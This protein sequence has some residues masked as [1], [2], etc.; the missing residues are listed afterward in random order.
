M[1]APAGA[2]LRAAYGRLSLSARLDF[3]LRKTQASGQDD[4]GFGFSNCVVTV[5]HD[6]DNGNDVFQQSS[7]KTAFL[8]SSSP[9]RSFDQ[10]RQRFL[11]IPVEHRRVWLR[12]ERVLETRKPL[13]LSTLEH[14]DRFCAV[15]F[16]DRHP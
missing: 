11:R 16:N 15:H 5:Q 8:A 4:R 10:A 7:W 2:T 6:F 14:D 3:G 1:L 9:L 12:K 13:P